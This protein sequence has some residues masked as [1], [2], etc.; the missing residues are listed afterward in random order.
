MSLGGSTLLS[1]RFLPCAC[2]FA[3][4]AAAPRVMTRARVLVTALVPLV[5]IGV[6]VKGFADADGLY[7]DLDAIL[8]HVPQGV[9]VAQL[10]LT[11]APVGLVAP[12]PGAAAR[13]LAERGG[14]MLFAFT[15][16]PPYPVYVRRDA[17]W[18]EP[19]LR[20]GTAPFAWMPARDATRFSY[21]LALHRS[22]A[23]R[24][25]VREALS[26]EEQLVVSQGRWDLYRSTLPTVAVDAMDVPL[27]EPPPETLAE[28]VNA[29][30]RRSAPRSPAR[31]TEAHEE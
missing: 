16:T 23:Y 5:T 29:A 9:A 6:N 24:H 22:E 21:L 13:V 27:P 4:I 2:A 12:V 10:D 28:R 15:D 30:L 1:H 26:R 31:S 8:A 25:L 3:I 19:M 20:M 11:P 14:R 17:Q 7:R 18:D